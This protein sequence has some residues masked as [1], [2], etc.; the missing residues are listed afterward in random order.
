[1]RLFLAP[2]EEGFLLKSATEESSTRLERSNALVIG[3]GA[4]GCQ[5]AQAIVTAG[6]G[7]LTLVDDDRVELSNLQRQILFDDADVGRPKAITA[8]LALR[9]RAP[10]ASIVARS[11]RVTANNAVPLLADHD[12]IIDATDDPE[13]KYLINR[14]AIE[15]GKPFV[16]GGVARTGGLAL[17]VQPGR[18]ACLACVFPPQIL[19]ANDSC[20]ALGILA[21]VAGAIGGLQAYLAIRLLESPT[22]VAG[23][24]YAYETRV[25]RWR[26]L[27]VDRDPK[28]PTCSCAAQRAA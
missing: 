23:L 25:R 21:P 28:C 22:E 16:Y 26:T 3:V 5:V 17:A 24:L 15:T 4:L 2:E 9:A 13:S 14:V 1:V 12:V 19:H 27:R 6:I 10:A 7:A 11:E 18:S 20:A 8:S